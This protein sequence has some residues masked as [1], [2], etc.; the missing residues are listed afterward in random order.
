MIL[1]IYKLPLYGDQYIKIN[2]GK[3]IRHMMY[4]VFTYIKHWSLYY[5]FYKCTQIIS[6]ISSLDTLLHLYIAH[7]HITLITN[8]D[9]FYLPLNNGTT[10]FIWDQCWC[11]NMFNW[12]E[13]GFLTSLLC[14]RALS[15][16]GA[17]AT[18]LGHSRVDEPSVIKVPRL[19]IWGTHVIRSTGWGKIM[20]ETLST[21]YC[22]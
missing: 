5:A 7:M 13:I 10:A 9:I 15:Y 19:P 18:H 4:N 11:N 17:E 3:D 12:H 2:H 20:S 16:Q 1:C 21:V 14:G 8:E 6:I 22:T